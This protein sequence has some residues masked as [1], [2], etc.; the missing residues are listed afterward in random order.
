[1]LTALVRTT[2]PYLV[3]FLVTLAIS[4]GVELN[5]AVTTEA[6]T[7]LV[8]SGYYALALFLQEKVSP[9]FGYLLLIPKSPAYGGETEEEFEDVGEV[10]SE[11]VP[12]IDTRSPEELAE[13]VEFEEGDDVDLFEGQAPV[14]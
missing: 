6:L 1:M 3:G 14:E 4:A 12:E 10:A 5:E 9:V 11:N 2:V 8:G 13:R 7:F